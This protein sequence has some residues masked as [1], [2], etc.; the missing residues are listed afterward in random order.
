MSESARPP[1]HQARNTVFASPGE[2]P[3]FFIPSANDDRTEES[4]QP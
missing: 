2:T 3:G 1:E 4:L